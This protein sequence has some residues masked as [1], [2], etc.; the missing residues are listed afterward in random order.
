MFFKKPAIP[1]TLIPPLIVN[2][3]NEFTVCGSSKDIPLWLTPGNISRS[4]SFIIYDPD[5]SLREQYGRPFRRGGYKVKLFNPANLEQS[6]K[7]NPFDYIKSDKDIPKLVTAI[8]NGTKS[9]G[10][11]GDISFLTL[12]SVL[13]TAL[14][15]LIIE[16]ALSNERNI[17]TVIEMLTAMEPDKN[18]DDYLDY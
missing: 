5:G 13:L 9:R 15:S 1:Q 10:K 4:T 14:I 3:V 16:D 2:C 12:E 17:S 18:P 11:R 8:L 6:A 7:Y